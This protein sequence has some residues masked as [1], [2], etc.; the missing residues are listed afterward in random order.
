MKKA[1]VHF[2]FIVFSFYI[3]ALSSCSSV[4]NIKKKRWPDGGFENKKYQ[5]F[6][7]IAD[8]YLTGIK[9][10][11]AVLVGKNGKI[12]FAKGYGSCDPKSADSEKNACH[13]FFL[14]KNR[15]NCP[16]NIC[17]TMGFHIT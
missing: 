17:G 12:I 11:G 14:V 13:Q 8:D 1:N 9:F 4:S 6:N 7:K 10:N 15:K 2:F 3:I 16:L 5:K